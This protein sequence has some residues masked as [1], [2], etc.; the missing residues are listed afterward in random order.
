MVPHL[1][2]DKPGGTTGEQDRPCNPGLQ[3]GEIK[4]QNLRLK[5]PVGVEA[6]GETL[7][8]TGEFIGDT[9]DPRMYTKPPTEESAPEGPSLLVGSGRGD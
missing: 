1:C 6:A 9:Q 7:S 2:A 5:T 4:P 8:L 3:S